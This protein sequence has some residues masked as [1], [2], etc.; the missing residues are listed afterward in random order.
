[1]ARNRRSVVSFSL[2]SGRGCI[3]VVCVGCRCSKSA[4]NLKVALAGRASPLPSVKN[5][6]AGSATTAMAWSEGK[7]FAPVAARIKAT[8][9]RMA[10]RRLGSAIASTPARS[11]SRPKE[12]PCRTNSVEA[13]P[14]VTSGR[15]EVC[16]RR[17]LVRS[18]ERPLPPPLVPTLA[19]EWR[20]LGESNPSCKIE[21]LES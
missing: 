16:A 20:A 4:P 19:N 2:R 10:R 15:A 11:G 1:M 13:L 8:S 5:I 12:I 6:C 21:N 18:A 7:S 3:L 14:K 9:F 17:L